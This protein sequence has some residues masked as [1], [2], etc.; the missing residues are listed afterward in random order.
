MP[1]LISNSPFAGLDLF[2]MTGFKV[3]SLDQKPKNILK[4][5]LQKYLTFY[6]MLHI[7]GYYKTSYIL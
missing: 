5:S 6:N 1:L 7:D 3:G 4:N 2:S